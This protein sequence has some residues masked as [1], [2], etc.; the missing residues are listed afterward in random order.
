[1][2]LDL[3]P[4][5]NPS[6]MQTKQNL[7]IV[8]R[9]R[10]V[11]TSI[12]SQTSIHSHLASTQ[13]SSP[14]ASSLYSGSYANSVS[15]SLIAS[16]YV[17]SAALM[18]SCGTTNETNSRGRACWYRDVYTRSVSFEMESV[19]GCVKPEMARQLSLW[20]FLRAVSVFGV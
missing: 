7:L 10:K 19:L 3:Y 4:T 14:T 13:F 8:D 1:M 12:F 18:I 17:F 20:A 9:L 16:L 5:H 2:P 6:A 11:L 15:A